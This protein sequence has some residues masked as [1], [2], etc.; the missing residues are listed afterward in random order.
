MTSSSFRFRLLLGTGATLLAT[1]AALV[2]GLLG[3]ETAELVAAATAL[4]ASALSFIWVL[5]ARRQ[6]GH[7]VPLSSDAEGTA[8]FAPGG[9]VAM[10]PEPERAFDSEPVMAEPAVRPVQ[11]AV[12]DYSEVL[13]KI[14]A[15]CREIS[16]GNFEARLI[17]IPGT[18]K[19]AAAQHAINDMIDRCDA[20]VR[21]ASAAMDAVRHHKYY[22]RILREGLNGMLDNAAASINE[23]TV[24]IQKRAAAFDAAG[25]DIRQGVDRSSQIARQA[26]TRADEANRTI[27]EL[28]AAAERIGN[29]VDL[30]GT[31]ASQTN[32]L[33][34]NAA[35][36]AAHA[37]ESG[38]GFAVVAQEV[39]ALSNQTAGATKE[40]SDYMK[41]VLRTTK[42]AV[43]EI[44]AIGGII[45]EI[46]QSTALAM[47][48][49]LSQVAAEDEF[50]KAS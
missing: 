46:D 1:L 38:K 2:F 3:W 14:T 31:I 42:D 48:A 32:L 5:K 47:K 49:V 43:V 29:S 39:K 22:R 26:V 21:E 6:G 4:A 44:E 13:D 12:A 37:G 17:G 16:K 33:A 27:K 25:D 11:N 50:A 28:S 35:I 18:G 7:L 15:A 10:V 19:D 20:F 24:A 40:I 8:N 41:R 45:N 9:R 23:A 34:L 36:E 30:I